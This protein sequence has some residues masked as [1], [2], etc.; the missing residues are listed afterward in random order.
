MTK[1]RCPH[2]R[3]MIEMAHSA[4]VTE[5]EGKLIEKSEYY[6]DPTKTYKT[7]ERSRRVALSYYYRNRAAVLRR[8]R[9]R[10]ELSRGVSVSINDK[11]NSR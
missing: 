9:R 1:I 2:C 8:E 10:R 4:F 5:R 3:K 11:D 7:E 6:P